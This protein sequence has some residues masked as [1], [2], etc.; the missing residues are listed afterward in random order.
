MRW[1]SPHIHQE[2]QAIGNLPEQLPRHSLLI[3]RQFP[4]FEQ[5][6]SLTHGEIAQLSQA[7]IG[8]L[9]PCHR[10]PH[11]RRIVPQ[12]RSA[13]SRTRHLAHQMLELMAVSM[14]DARGLI[15]G[16]EETLILKSE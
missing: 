10:Q 16:G 9:I 14:T 1:D 12:S 13:A 11:R 15:D 6:Q 4:G 2:L 7:N 8:T 3:A 5:S